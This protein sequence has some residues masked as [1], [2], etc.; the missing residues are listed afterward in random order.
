MPGCVH[1][2]AQV[3]KINFMFPPPRGKN[4]TIKQT[5]HQTEVSTEEANPNT[6]TTFKMLEESSSNLQRYYCSC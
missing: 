2:S 3:V 4:G 6:K 5:L 1:P